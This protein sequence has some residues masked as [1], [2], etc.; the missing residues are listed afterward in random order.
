MTSMPNDN[1][2]RPLPT[3]G[4]ADG[5][6]KTIAITGSSTRNATPIASDVRVISLYATTACFLRFGDATVTASN[7][8]HFLPGGVYLDVAVGP[9]TKDRYIAALRSSADG[10]LYVS[11]R[12]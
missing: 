11:E 2:G 3:L 7:T 8:D 5:G 12:I 6:A 4:F 10:T 9:D 1:L